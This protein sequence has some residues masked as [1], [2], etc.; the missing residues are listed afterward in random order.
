[1]DDRPERSALYYLFLADKE[2][3]PMPEDA[4][5]KI[6]IKFFEEFSKK[7]KLFQDPDPPND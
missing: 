1:M 7:L 6:R 3:H 4:C 2:A 5:R